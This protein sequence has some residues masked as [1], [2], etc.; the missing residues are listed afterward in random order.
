VVA[1]IYGVQPENTG[2]RK[3]KRQAPIISGGIM[4]KKN[5]NKDD[6]ETT[7]IRRAPVLAKGGLGH[8]GR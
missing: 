2:L 3:V 8:I 1:T 5:H 7:T 4:R 6:N